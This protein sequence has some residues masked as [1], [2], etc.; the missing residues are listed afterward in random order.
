MIDY[1]SVDFI[2]L[3]ENRLGLRNVQMTAGG[4]EVKFSCHRPEHATG[5]DDPSAY[6]NSDT[7][8]TFCHGCGFKGTAPDLVADVQ[9]TSRQSAERFLREIYGVTFNEPVGGSMAVETD[10]RFRDA[11]PEPP[12]IVPPESWLA[13]V[14]VDWDAASP[15]HYEAYM[16]DRG[17]MP[18]TLTE[19][20]CGY[21]FLSDRLT[22][23]V[24]DL[25]GVLFGVKGRD[26]TGRS[27]ARYMVIGNVKRR[28]LNYG[29]DT[30]EV[31]EVVFGLHRAREHRTAILLEGELDAM[32]LSQICVP[33]PVASGRAG[34]SPRQVEL[35]VDEC[36][37]VVVYYDRGPA[38]EQATDQAVELLEPRLRVRVVE[39]LDVDPCDALKLGREREVLQAIAEARSSLLARP[40]SGR[41][42]TRA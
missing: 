6:I 25:D 21:E 20:E 7:S 8:A 24:R 41:V 4:I 16:L 37:E 15:Q 1:S 36:D 11:L 32:A 33:R 38:G 17:L 27:R 29:F 35:L 31:S 30:Y 28:K 23:P 10:L 18:S 42:A 2:D 26:W 40:Y 9:Q 14:R 22:I 5:D 3:L 34:L 12:R 39:P 19:W 13:S